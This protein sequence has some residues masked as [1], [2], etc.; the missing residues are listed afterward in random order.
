MYYSN[1][2]EDDN[3]GHMYCWHRRYNIGDE[4]PFKTPQEFADSLKTDSYLSLTIFMYDHSIQRISVHSFV[5]RAQHAEWDSGRIG[6]IWCTK[7][8]ARKWFGVKRLTKE[9]EETVYKELEHEVE[10]YDEW[11]N[12]SDEEEENESNED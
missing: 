8:E 9:L 6:W 11:M 1:P 12:N 2:R 10:D 5:G 4:H 7:Q 3:L